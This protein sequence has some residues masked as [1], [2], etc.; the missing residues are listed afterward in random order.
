MH[1][2]ILVVLP[3]LLYAQSQPPSPGPG[4]PAQENKGNAISKQ[5]V[6]SSDQSD[7]DALSTAVDKLASEMA[8]WKKQEPAKQD[9]N[10]TSAEWWAIGSAAVSTLA[11]VAI[12]AL[13]FFQWRAMDKQRLA[14]DTQATYMRDGLE[15]TRN[16]IRC[17]QRERDSG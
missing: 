13:A 2:L 5:A 6:A 11:T 17:G 9:I 15:A 12:A 10:N 8:S 4:K 7:A 3:I 14:M 1:A 16:A